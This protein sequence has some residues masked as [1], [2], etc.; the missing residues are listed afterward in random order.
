MRLRAVKLGVFH[1]SGC[2][3]AQEW[4][5]TISDFTEDDANSFDEGPAAAWLKKTSTPD[6]SL[7]LQCEYKS[8]LRVRCGRDRDDLL[9]CW[10]TGHRPT[11]TITAHIYAHGA[12]H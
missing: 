10:H 8:Y 5:R 7:R 12:D 11:A 3:Y 9:N 6:Q 4:V 1:R 2:E